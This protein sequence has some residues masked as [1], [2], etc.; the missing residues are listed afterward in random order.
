[1]LFYYYNLAVRHRSRDPFERGSV[2]N[3]AQMFTAPKRNQRTVVSKQM[4]P[5]RHCSVVFAEGARKR[6]QARE[7]GKAGGEKGEEVKAEE[8]I[9]KGEDGQM[10]KGIPFFW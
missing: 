4:F 10:K 2:E 6:S 9:E 3:L 1:M 5:G 7:E 8:R